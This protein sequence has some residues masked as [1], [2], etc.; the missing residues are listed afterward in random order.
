MDGTLKVTVG[1]GVTQLPTQTSQFCP[2]SALLLAH[3]QSSLGEEEI[4]NMARQVWE[5]G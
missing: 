3:G 5:Q 1:E 2:C 4:S